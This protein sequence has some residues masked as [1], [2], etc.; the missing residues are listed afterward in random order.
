MKAFFFSFL[1]CCA[2]TT[3]ILAQDDFEKAYIQ[4][5][6]ELKEPAGSYIVKIISSSPSGFYALRMKNAGAL[7]N[8]QVYI[9]KYDNKMNLK[10]SVKLDLKYKGKDREFEN[11]VM[12]KGQ[13]YLLTSFNNEAQKKNYLFLQKISKDGL[14]L[15]KDFEMIGETE[16]RDKIREGTFDLVHSQD[17]S[18]ILIYNQLLYKKNEPERFAFRIFDDQ[19]NELWSRNIVLPYGDDQ[20]SVEEYQI[21]KE[22]NV[23]LL[24]VIYDDKSKFRRQ[25]K[26]TYRYTILAYTRDGEDAQEY[27]IDIQ[28][29]FITDLTFKVA[30]DGNLI[31]TGFFF[32]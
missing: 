2:F 10:R 23:Y 18:K 20:F 13:L 26:P 32:V 7:N 16:S 30:D 4:W 6:K 31:C 24:G 27:K 19:F 17:S 9:E 5:G 28:D 3:G 12:I 15:A 29:K 1:I 21:D 11:V 22:G 8:E 14:R 25:G